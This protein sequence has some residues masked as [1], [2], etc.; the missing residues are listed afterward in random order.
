MATQRHHGHGWGLNLGQSPPRAQALS[1]SHSGSHGKL[2]LQAPP[3]HS[4]CQTVA[5][6]DNE[7]AGE[8]LREIPRAA[9]SGVTGTF[10]GAI[11]RVFCWGHFP[12]LTQGFTA[13]SFSAREATLRNMAQ[14]LGNGLQESPHRSTAAIVCALTMGQN[15]QPSQPRISPRMAMGV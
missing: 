8:L 13:P 6:G 9:Q 4:H 2:C 14:Q 11:Y 3:L 12:F 10:L 15:L 1:G 5:R 7:E